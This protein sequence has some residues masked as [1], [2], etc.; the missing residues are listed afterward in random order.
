M[1]R[2]LVAAAFGA[3]LCGLGC[4]G[5]R[6]VFLYGRVQNGSGRSVARAPVTLSRFPGEDC[7]FGR[8]FPE[9][10]SP[11]VVEPFKHAETNDDGRFLFQLLQYDLATSF[12]YR[13]DV[14]GGKDG[15]KTSVWTP[16]GP[17]YNLDV[18]LDRVYRWDEGVISLEPTV[19]GHLL[20][21]L[22]GPLNRSERVRFGVEDVVSYEWALTALGKP[23][24]RVEQT[25]SPLLVDGP[26]REDFG[27]VEAHGVMLSILVPPDLEPTPLL[28]SAASYHEHATGPAVDL[29]SINPLLPVSRGA[30]CS[31]RATR[32]DPCPAT[33]GKLDLAT[34]P[35]PFPRQPE[36]GLVLELT[37]PSTPSLAIF[38]DVWSSSLSLTL[39]GSPDGV[40]WSPLGSL[41]MPWNAGSPAMDRLSPYEWQLT[42]MSAGGRFLRMELTPPAQPIT[43]IRARGFRALRELSVF[44]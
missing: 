4:A 15:A 33:D 32:F 10:Q 17:L 39:E 8:S 18:H 1:A 11:A 27:Q 40:T 6:P 22:P 20:S 9:Q 7:L 2:T 43:R 38:R 19:D 31:I 36:D 41:E 35:F 26:I 5:D 13:T 29:P 44:D 14:E 42:Q 12:C 37:A 34:F 23:L 21:S 25:G 30:P 24:W 16:L 28:G 3:I